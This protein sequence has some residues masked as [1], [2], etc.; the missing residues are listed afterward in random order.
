MLTLIP[1]H[2]DFIIKQLSLFLLYHKSR[3]ML[4]RKYLTN[5]EDKPN[6]VHSKKESLNAS[7]QLLKGQ[8]MAYDATTIPG[9]PLRNNRWFL[10]TI[11]MHDF[12]LAAMLVS[13]K[14]IQATK[15]GVTVNNLSN[16]CNQGVQGLVTA[17][18]RSRMVWEKTENQQSK[19]ASNLVK[20]MLKRVRLA[21]NGQLD[22]TGR[23]IANSPDVNGNDQL[24]LISGLALNGTYQFVTLRAFF[25]WCLKLLDSQ[26]RVLSL[27]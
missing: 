7:V 2:A 15:E 25:H 27:Y 3:C 19:K 8:S 10:T 13:M 26:I 23:I 17:L 1:W 9:G 12:L 6:Y 20:M 22:S 14:I 4:H 16:P 24:D 18:E 5:M 11:S 21:L